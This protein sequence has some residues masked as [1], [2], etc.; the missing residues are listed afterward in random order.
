MHLYKELGVQWSVSYAYG[1]LVTFTAG[2]K[3]RLTLWEKKLNQKK[4]AL[5]TLLINIFFFGLLCSWCYIKTVTLSVN[6]P[7][8]RPSVR[9]STPPINNSNSFINLL[10]YAK[11]ENTH[12]V[13]QCYNFIYLFYM[14]DHQHYIRIT[15]LALSHL[16]QKYF[17]WEEDTEISEDATLFKICP[18]DVRQHF[19]CRDAI[20]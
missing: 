14:Y 20:T 16:I 4:N 1:K 10:L 9:P 17:S 5:V 6:P 8:V 19:Y 15:Q 13:Y 7:Q 2:D 3:M 11:E 12:S 18:R